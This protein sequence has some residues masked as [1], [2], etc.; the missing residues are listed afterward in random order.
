MLYDEVLKDIEEKKI[1]REQGNFNGIPLCFPRYREY[2][3]SIDKGIY[4]GLLGSTGVGK[5]RVCRHMFVYEPLKFSLET[6]YPLKILYFA[7]EDGKHR[8]FK[9]IISHYLWERHKIYV[10]APVLESKDKPLPDYYLQYIRKDREFFK[11]F[12]DI[13]HI[14]NDRLTPKEIF[15]ACVSAHDTFGKTHHILVIIDNYANVIKEKKHFN[16][17]EAV[18][19]LSRDYIRLKLCKER[20]MTVVSILQQDMES[21]KA[22]FRA[23]GQKGI[24]AIEPNMG[25]IGENKVISRDKGL[26]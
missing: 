23:I 13:V 22:T 3:P 25:S 21:E 18:K 4:Y 10:P 16:D 1:N 14:I 2:V 24:A 5:S 20:D 11:K 6:G 15:D 12:E 9:K 26:Y 19:E 8:I 17:W 7:L